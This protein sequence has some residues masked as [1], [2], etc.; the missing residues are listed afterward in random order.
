M[1]HATKHLQK[2]WRLS[3]SDRRLLVTAVLLLTAM[4][5]GLWLLPFRTLR[6][7][8]VCRAQGPSQS[9]IRMPLLPERIGWA[10]ATAGRYVPRA[11]CL[12]QALTAQLLLER[13]EY[14]ARLC[15]GLART[16]GKRIQAHA[17]VESQG[18]VLLGSGELS[19]YTVL[20]ALEGT[21]T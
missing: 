1:G 18:R 12:T 8:L 19:R 11:T 6:R 9:A 15:I 13:R 10:V 2:F 17:W 14:P 5:L 3:P 7:I 4:R 20:L 16:E 21:R